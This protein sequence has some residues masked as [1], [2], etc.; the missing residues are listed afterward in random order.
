VGALGPE[1]SEVLAAVHRDHGVEL[2][3]GAQV[4]ALE[5]GARVQRVRLADGS[6]VEADVVVVGIG[7]RPAIEWLESSGLALD[8]GVV[9][10][11]SCA[12]AAPDI[13]AAGDVARWHNPLF[14]ESMRLEHWTNAVEQSNAAAE[15]LLAG[16]EGAR[17]YAPVPFVWSDQYDRKIQMAGRV[18]PDCEV[19]IVHGSPQERRFVALYGRQGRLVG[20]VALNRARQ[21]MGF[22]RQ[23]REGVAFETAVAEARRPRGGST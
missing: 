12:T 13:V 10:D 22:R 9:C 8:D 2:R 23:I 3:L 5:G 21:L 18:G 19:R 1:V 15:R 16:P 4:S 14:G 20:A 11:E 17:P 7:V 6:A